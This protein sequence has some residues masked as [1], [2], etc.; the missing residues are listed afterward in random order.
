ML[1]D[2]SSYK[3]GSLIQIQ[4]NYIFLDVEEKNTDFLKENFDIEVYKIDNEG[5]E[6]RLYFFNEDSDEEEYKKHILERMTPD[7]FQE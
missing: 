7:W 1:K 4:P 6:E 5:K 3:D 2:F